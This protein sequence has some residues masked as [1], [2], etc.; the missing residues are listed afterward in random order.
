MEYKILLI[1]D[2][3][4]RYLG[5]ELNH[6]FHSIDHQLIWR[7]GLTLHETADFAYNTILTYKPHLV[8]VLP[9]IC[10]I[11]RIICRDPRAIGLRDTSVQ[12]TVNNFLYFLDKAHREIYSLK[13]MVGH[14]MMIITPTLTGVDIGRYN[15]YPDDL[16]FPHQKILDN[17]ILNINRAITAMN[18]SMN[19]FTPFLATPVHPRCRRRN[20]FVYDKLYDGCHPSE[21]LC[22]TWANKL[23]T[24]AWRN[25]DYYPAYTLINA[26]Y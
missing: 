11:T 23:Y 24:N 9:G 21:S 25:A 5:R 13:E 15:H 14:E 6:V 1:A 17:S 12:G 8:Y 4:G 10:D 16:K 26:M 22:A 18:F 7:G 2:S 20:R 19:I 3:R